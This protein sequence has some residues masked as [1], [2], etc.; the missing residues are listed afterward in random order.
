[1]RPRRNQQA[2]PDRFMTQAHEYFTGT[3]AV[4]IENAITREP[5]MLAIHN[6]RQQTILVGRV[7]TVKLKFVG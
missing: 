5:Q 1:M 7:Y 6:S 4:K 3:D 2:A